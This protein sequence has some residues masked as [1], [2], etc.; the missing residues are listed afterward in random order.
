MAHL[1]YLF[2]FF[3]IHILSQETG[4]D[5]REYLH[6]SFSIDYFQ[7]NQNQATLEISRAKMQL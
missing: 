1:H 5:N 4:M 6:L 2:Y 3:S 7:E